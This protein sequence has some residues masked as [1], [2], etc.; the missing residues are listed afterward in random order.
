MGREQSIRAEKPTLRTQTQ[1]WSS[2][3]PVLL[4]APV[5]KHSSIRTTRCRQHHHISHIAGARFV[6]A[7][8]DIQKTHFAHEG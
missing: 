1:G 7:S 3:R 6:K 8:S 2:D 4:T 5:R